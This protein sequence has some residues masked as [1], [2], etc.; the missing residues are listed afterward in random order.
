MRPRN[1]LREL[2]K[3]AG[4][5]QAELAAE[6]GVSQP[7][8]SQI[9]NDASPMDTRWMRAFARALGCAPAD[10]LDDQDNPDR[11]SEEERELIHKYRQASRE[12]QELIARVA[13]PVEAFK[14]APAEPEPLRKRA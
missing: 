10:L 6:T 3:A 14:P 11:L 4:L 8:I 13:A 5:S 2:R 7:A 12:Q 9:E 1:R